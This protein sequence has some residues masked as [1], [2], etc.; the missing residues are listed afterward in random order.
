MDS[1]EPGA[2]AEKPKSSLRRTGRAPLILVLLALVAGGVWFA[3]RSRGPGEAAPPPGAEPAPAAPVTPPEPEAEVTAE[4][5]EVRSLL[6]AAS[7]D[8]TYRSWLAQEDLVRRAAVVVENLAEGVSPRAELGFLAPRQ[9]FSTVTRG[10]RTQIAPA[11]YA[12]YDRFA[13][14]IG[15][16]DAAA[17]AKAYRALRP[18]LQTA[19]RALGSSTSIDAALARALARLDAAPVRD[20]AVDVISDEGLFVYGDPTLERLPE[21][22]KHLLRMGPRNTRL[23][24]A[25]ARELRAAIGLEPGAGDPAGVRGKKSGARFPW[26]RRR[27]QPISAGDDVVTVALAART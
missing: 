8:E 11:S 24:Q 18:A 14:A 3:T 25:K 5:A 13:D 2:P 7:P 21:V 27:R 6:E 1:H 23:V 19:T 26:P 10:G 9:P 20:G 16:L 22:E 15:S 12:R 4:P 17:L